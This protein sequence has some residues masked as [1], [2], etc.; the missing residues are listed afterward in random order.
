METWYRIHDFREAPYC[1]E[2]G[3]PE[4]SSTPAVAVQK[5]LVKKRTPKGVFVADGSPR[6]RFILNTSHKKFACPTIELA[7][8]SWKARKARERSIYAARIR[9]I[10]E[11]LK[12]KIRGMNDEKLEEIYK[13]LNY[14]SN[15]SY[16]E[17]SEEDEE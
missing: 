4:G 9:H 14:I 8:E 16:N 3:D 10:D 1:N 17:V 15:L 2:F 7:I 11:V 6:G 13:Q 5:Y 12:C